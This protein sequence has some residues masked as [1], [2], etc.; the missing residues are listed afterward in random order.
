MGKTGELRVLLRF[1]ESTSLE[2]I[3]LTSVLSAIYTSRTQSSR[4][5]AHTIRPTIQSLRPPCP[6]RFRASRRHISSQ[7]CFPCRQAI[8]SR[9]K[10][11]SEPFSNPTSTLLKKTTPSNL[12]PS[13]S[14][15]HH[16][17]HLHAPS[18][19][20]DTY[21]PDPPA[22]SAPNAS[23]Q[24]PARNHSSSNSSAPRRFLLSLSHRSGIHGEVELMLRKLRRRTFWVWVWLGICS[25]GRA[26]RCGM[27][28]GLRGGG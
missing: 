26:A 5:L 28:A 1:L 9:I 3:S 25:R 23:P 6:T 20:P 22:H 16:H 17:P 10:G 2:S 13:P 4:D 27:S 19:T 14:H 12:F 11:I 24:T 18:S 15:Q 21:S 7:R 8:P